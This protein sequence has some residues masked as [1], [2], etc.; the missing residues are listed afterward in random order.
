MYN[1]TRKTLGR[2]CRIENKY[3][4]ILSELIIIRHE[5]R[6]LPGNIGSLI[7]RLNKSATEMH[8]QC[9]KERK[10]YENRHHSNK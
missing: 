2:L 4:R 5:I 1:N 3:D 7:D 10:T 8:R 6:A 9:L